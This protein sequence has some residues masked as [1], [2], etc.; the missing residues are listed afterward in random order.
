DKDNQSLGQDSRVGTLMPLTRS[1]MVP[2]FN[3][4][5]IHRW[6]FNAVNW[7][8]ASADEWLIAQDE[9]ED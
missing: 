2:Y 3:D 7:A 4:Q 6:T 1:A 9:D 5:V 8:I